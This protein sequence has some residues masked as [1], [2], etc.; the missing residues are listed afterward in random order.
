MHCHDSNGHSS[1]VFHVPI[2]TGLSEQETALL[3]QAI[4]SQGYKKGEFVFREG[5][6][7][8]AL[9]VIHEGVLKVT[10][11]SN[12]G[13][14]HILR[15]LF[16]GDFGG[17]FALFKE[18][19]HYGN[20]EAVETSVVCRI[21]RHDLKAILSTNSE[22]AYRF[23]AAM[24][25]RLR[26]ADEWIGSM[27]LMDAERRL[28]KILLLYFARIADVGTH[29]LPIAK[30]DLAGMIGVAPETVSRKLASLEAQGIISLEG[31]KGIHIINP[32]ALKRISDSL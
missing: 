29:H 26:D 13:K 16:P 9:Y 8:D 15:F 4:Y 19:L 22:M 32:S 28:A 23:L 18:G 14:E 17:L 2:F 12:A 24:S 11:L 3:N 5:E 7:S 25:E 31:K 6:L 27:S 1:C 21:Y 10:T 20:A 30:K